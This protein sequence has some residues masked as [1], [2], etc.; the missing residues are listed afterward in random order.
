MNPKLNVIN[1]KIINSIHIKKNFINVIKCKLNLCSLCNSNHDESHEPI[2]YDI[3][4]YICE[5]HNEKYISYCKTCKKDI[6]SIC[7]EDHND[8]ETI[9]YKKIEKEK[10]LEE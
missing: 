5:D 1:V 3:K 6:C 9:I 8:H 10:K 2:N 7:L 4:N